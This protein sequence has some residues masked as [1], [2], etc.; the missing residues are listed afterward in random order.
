MTSTSNHISGYADLQ[1]NGFKGVDFSAPE[2]SEETFTQACRGLLSHGT[3]LFLPTLITSPPEVYRHNLSLMAKAIREFAL[4]PY[5]PGFHLEGPFISRVD[6]A[7]GAHNSEY[8]ARP[9]P[10]LLDQLMEWADGRIRLLTLAADVPGADIVCRHA[11]SMGITV[12]LGHHMA[13]LAD[14]ERLADNGARAL[15]HLGNALPALLPRHENPLLAG[16]ACDRLTAMIIADGHHLPASLVQIILKVKGIEHVVVVS[17][18][19]PVAGL[20]P[21]TYHTLGNHVRLEENGLL[22]NPHT[23]YMV[24]S[25]FTMSECA[26]WLKTLP[27]P[28]PED[29]H[30]LT[31]NNALRLIGLDP[32]EV[33]SSTPVDIARLPGENPPAAST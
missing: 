10:K 19:A 5:I 2:L 11:V 12:S 30:Q 8:I 14:L 29:H 16:L 25:S 7:R 9:D 3:R 1:V 32:E 27:E 13:T 24:G 31:F 22:H 21:G 28:G 17:D 20:P 6:G 15:T 4:E 33:V 23:G 26:R 18:A